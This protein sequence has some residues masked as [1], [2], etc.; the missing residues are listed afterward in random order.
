MTRTKERFG[1][2]PDLVNVGLGTVTAVWLF[3]VVRVP[4]N[5]YFSARRVRQELEQSEKENISIDPQDKKS[6]EKLEP[7]LLI[8]S[9]GSHVVS[10]GIIY[11]ISKVTKRKVI[12]EE[13]SL[14][15]LGSAFIRPIWEAHKYVREQLADLFQRVRYPRDDVKKLTHQLSQM[16]NNVEQ[17][18]EDAEEKEK[19]ISELETENK[20]QRYRI[21]SL[22]K[23]LQDVRTTSAAE[24]RETRKMIKGISNDF[25]NKIAQVSNNEEMIKGV[26]AFVSM[27]RNEQE[28]STSSS[29][30]E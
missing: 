30:T 3:L 18:N 17:M 12:R 25:E 15:F 1:F 29:L 5:L 8:G 13:A 10:A 16:E 21:E 14:L 6:V 19:K 4:W 7:R 26:K 11:A 27:L 28:T 20:N 24:T 22:E 2:V 23:E 9:L